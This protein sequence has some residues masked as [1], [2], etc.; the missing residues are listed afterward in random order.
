MANT[1]SSPVSDQNEMVLVLSD[2]GLVLGNRVLSVNK[3]GGIVLYESD[4]MIAT[5]NHVTMA[6]GTA[7]VGIGAW[8]L[9][10]GQ[11]AHNTVVGAGNGNG[12]QVLTEHDNA[13]PTTSQR[14]LIE[15]NYIRNV[16]AAI[17]LVETEYDLF[18][19]NR[20]QT[21]ST[22]IDYVTGTAVTRPFFRGNKFMDVTNV[23]STGTAPVSPYYTG[24]SDGTTDYFG[25]GV[26]T[27]SEPLHVVGSDG[28]NPITAKVQNSHALGGQDAQLLLSLSSTLTNTSV[29][30]S[31]YADR[32]DASSSGDTDLLLKSSAGTTMT[33]RMRFKANGNS[34]IGIHDPTA[35]LHLPAGS[36]S[37]NTAPL[38]FTSG[39]YNSAAEAGA[40]E[41][42]GRF[43]VTETDAVRRYVVQALANTKTT[44]GA[45][46][47]ND[48]YIEVVINGTTVKLMTTA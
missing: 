20:I 46:Y 24:N 2:Y 27:P 5:D 15:G 18:N 35:K 8:S 13:S 40:M 45:P 39:N 25:I 12:I 11:I 16:G 21:C 30:A 26:N 44:A 6:S 42:N 43:A 36:T 23:V 33:S 31:V 38:K 4:Y 17:S 1:V 41:Y 14:N 32:T 9:R 19:S 7:H 34:A 22:G 48:G 29:G 3:N 47:T 10:W 28:S 37:A